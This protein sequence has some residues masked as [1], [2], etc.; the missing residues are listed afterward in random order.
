MK[1]M[2]KSLSLL[3]CICLLTGALLCF[4]SCQKKE[5]T[6]DLSGYQ[7]VYDSSYK[8]TFGAWIKHF[9]DGKTIKTGTSTAMVETEAEILVGDTSR[10]QTAELL[11]KIEG[12][13]Y[14][15]GFVDGKIVVIGT[16]KLMTVVAVEAF[17]KA[18]LAGEGATITVKET[19]VSNAPT[20]QITGSYSVLYNE[21]WDDT[22]NDGRGPNTT[23]KIPT[24]W[25]TAWWQQSRPT[26]H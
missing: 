25:I 9:G 18:C 10:P 3:L 6:V 7:L 16:T 11:G 19:V 13:G 15:F 14:A 17:R 26:R 5:V 24:P 1:L 4:T 2:K 22:K 20:V 23:Q 12:E 21:E 8:N